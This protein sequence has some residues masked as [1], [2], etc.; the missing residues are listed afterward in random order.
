MKI[1]ILFFAWL[2]LAL[3]GCQKDYTLPIPSPGPNSLID[4]THPLK[5]SSKLILEGVYQVSSETAMFGEEVIIK[6]N[7]T[8]L[9][10]ATKNGKYM[11]LECGYLDSVVFL[12]GYWRDGYSDGTGLV[13][14]MIGKDEG[15][16]VVV[17]GAANNGITIRGA[18]GESSNL[19]DQS[20]V[21]TWS[22]PFS[23]KV[24]NSNYYILAHRG[25]GRTSDLLPVSENSLAMI[26]FTERLGSTGIEVDVRISKDDVPFLYHDGDLNIRLTQK[27]PLAGPAENFTFSQLNQFVT[28]IH[29]EKI[30]SLE[31]AL[32]FTIDSTLLNF[33][34]LDMKTSVGAMAKVIPVQKRMMERA[35]QKGRNILIVIGIP[36]TEALDDLKAY[37]GYQDVPSLCELTVD[38]VRAVNSKVW[39]PRWT[40]GTQNDLVGQMHSEGR[41]AVCWTIDQPAWIRDYI[42]DGIFDG[43]LTNFPY[44]V[45][46]YHYIQN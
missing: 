41:L 2:I 11:V 22:R 43:L 14:M 38:D 45:A 8:N 4:Q 18:F 3:Y 31:E 15:G 10:I 1:K 36:T 34:Y 42:N 37:P 20:I 13:S 16:S 32:T 24:Q 33:V 7:R 27:G 30:P 6:N 35:Q 39:G 29:G 44:V 26:G 5:A 28:L 25:G 40:L 46:Y 9:L 21:L 19:P 23:G 12:Q 17:A